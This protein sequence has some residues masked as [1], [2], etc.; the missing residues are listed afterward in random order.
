MIRMCHGNVF[1]HV[2][3]SVLLQLL[4][5]LTYTVHFWYAGTPLE[6]LGQVVYQDYRVKIKFTGAKQRGYVSS[7][8]VVCLR[9][10]RQSCLFASWIIAVSMFC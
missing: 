6:Y 5:A 2:R 7:S 10:K 4:K 8:R 9:F 1:G 3:L